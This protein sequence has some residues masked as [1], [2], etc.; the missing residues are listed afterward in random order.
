MPVGNGAELATLFCRGCSE[1]PNDTDNA[2]LLA[3][4]KDSLGDQN[5]END[6]LLCV[7]LLSYARPSVSQRVLSA[8]PFFYWRLNRGTRVTG[9]Q[10]VR[11]LLDLTALQHPMMTKM[12]RE[13]LQRSM[14]DTSATPVRASSR[15]Y[16][17]N[18][19]DQE[20]LHLEQ[21]ISY[22]HAAPSGD[23]LTKHQLELL[24][25]RLDLRKSLMGSFVSE[26][27]AARHGLATDMQA[28]RIRERNWEL[29]RQCADK[30]GLYFEPIQVAGT[31]G[32]YVI[33]WTPVDSRRIAAMA[34]ERPIWKL[35]N[36]KPP[37]LRDLSGARTYVRGLDEN[38]QLV[39]EGMEGERTIRLAPLGVYSLTYPKLPLLLVDFRSNRHIRWRA[40]TQRSVND[41]TA[42]VIGISHFA[43]WYY[44][45]AADAYDFIASRR[46][47]AMNQSARLDS[48]AQF[49]SRL[50]LDRTLEPT[51]RSDM[52][53]RVKS[54][55][56]NPLETAPEHELLAAHAHF[57]GLLRAAEDGRLQG[58]V[59]KDRRAELAA[60]GQSRPRMLWDSFLHAA[61]FGGY[62][63][64]A[65]A[66]PSTLAQLDV[67]RR[68]QFQ[69]DFLDRLAEKGTAPEVS[70]EIDQI[71]RSV[72]ELERLAP[73]T[74]LEKLQQHAAETLERLQS[75]SLD[76]GLQ[77]ELALARVQ[78]S[79][80]GTSAAL[81]Q[82][83]PDTPTSRGFRQA[84]GTK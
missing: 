67:L 7:W 75:Q 63:H 54:L 81:T 2:P 6:R 21:A 40:I 71:R 80:E 70:F 4:L 34:D 9:S 1:A 15:A 77:Q 42:G 53:Q 18:E 5:V 50:A 13:I 56:M 36:L 46:G 20:R 14:F 45:V 60:Y 16:R 76:Q 83:V 72:A 38:G 24:S 33:L 79:G 26:R 39:P 48:Y 29:L 11:P 17:T 23:V 41:V 59:D 27:G 43:N 55:A 68:A 31:S 37:S 35:L 10:R 19:A 32:R 28:E 12:G 73:L 25:A 51:L 62:T 8:V 44:Y 66:E 78:V 22:L 61:S 82:V 57:E 30:T 52:V 49:R 64:R 58:I 3:V 65:P 84:G 47:A 69:L 74:G